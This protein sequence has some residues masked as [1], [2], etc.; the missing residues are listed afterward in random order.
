MR[1]PKLRPNA[2]INT[3]TTVTLP[4]A[5]PKAFC[6]N[7]SA[8]RS[9]QSRWHLRAATIGILYFFRQPILA[10]AGCWS[11]SV[12]IL[13]PWV[14]YP[15]IEIT[16]VACLGY[17]SMFIWQENRNCQ[18]SVLTLN[19]FQFEGE[20]IQLPVGWWSV[21]PLALADIPTVTYSRCRIYN[22]TSESVTVPSLKLVSNLNLNLK[23]YHSL[24]V[25][26]LNWVQPHY[27][28]SK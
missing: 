27:G 26:K 24:V 6:K 4:K 23:S 16:M 19:T 9:C 10:A 5:G 28:Y 15:L 17:R 20:S 3:P 2:D 21:R 13:G 8:I 25:W 14:R 18:S 7:S 12:V 1:G 11:A 22:M